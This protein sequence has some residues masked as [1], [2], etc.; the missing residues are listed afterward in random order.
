MLYNNCS[1]YINVILYYI[2]VIK[3]CI[4]LIEHKYYK[5]IDMFSYLY[6][7]VIFI[8]FILDIKHYITI[9]IS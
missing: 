4:Q 5:V 3:L 8:E 2:S 1:T 9:Y 6:I 7:N